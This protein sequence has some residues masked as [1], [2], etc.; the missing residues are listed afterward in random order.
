MSAFTREELQAFIDNGMIDEDTVNQVK[1]LQERNDLLK[2]HKHKVW[3]GSDGYWHTYY[4]PKGATKRKPKKLKSEEDMKDFIVEHV[5]ETMSN[6]CTIESLYPIWL[7]N[8]ENQTDSPATIEK[9]EYNW[10]KYYLSDPNFIKKPI[11][12]MNRVYLKNWCYKK[13]HD[14]KLTSNAFT[15]MMLIVREIMDIAFE[16]CNIIDGNYAREIHIKK[17]AFTVR[18]KPKSEDTVLTVEMRVLMIKECMKM[19]ISESDVLALA[20]A[21]CLY[22]A[23]RVAEISGAKFED[24]TG[25]KFSI[26][27]QIVR[28]GKLVNGKYKR[29]GYKVKTSLKA[30]SERRT[31]EVHD[32]VIKI[33]SLIKQYNIGHNLPTDSFLFL[34]K[35]SFV[36]PKILNDELHKVCDRLEMKSKGFHGIR[37]TIASLII[38]G[39]GTLT[40]AKDYLGHASEATTINNYVFDVFGNEKS[41][42]IIKEAVSLPKVFEK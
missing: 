2:L 25:N 24:F 6:S 32:D 37:K 33:L 19:F 40:S 10:K 3:Y 9:I 38:A 31:I 8:R 14:F 34:H 18:P 1:E 21:I 11:N 28:N 13:I 42:V 29:L 5:R 39:G 7:E 30:G 36:N 26:Q 35:G 16:D 17:T 22:T 20:I 23:C 15:D 12:E 27:R 41:N 4:F